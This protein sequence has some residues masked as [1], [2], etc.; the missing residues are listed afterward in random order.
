MRNAIIAT[1]TSVFLLAGCGGPDLNDKLKI[2]SE[3]PDI[4]EITARY[5]K[6]A[7]EIRQR[8]SAELTPLDWTV[9]N[10]TSRGGCS[11][12]SGI[13]GVE[14]RTLGHWGALGAVPDDKWE[15]AV[16]LAAEVSKPYGFGPPRIVVNKP[17]DHEVIA[18]DSYDA[19]LI[20][21]T[22]VNTILSIHTGCH[23]MAGVQPKEA[24]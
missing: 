2:L 20:F 19:T 10:P 15:K 21:G 12:F 7:A 22:S 8:V 16:V 14:S 23:R 13:S 24:G 4:E 3:R 18:K 5:E 9:R 6:M 1:L 17:G 11:E